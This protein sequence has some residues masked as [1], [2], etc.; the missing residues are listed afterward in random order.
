[1][2]SASC[3]FPYDQVENGFPCAWIGA[4][5]EQGSC[6]RFLSTH[7]S[8]VWAKLV[9]LLSMFGN[10]CVPCQLPGVMARTFAG[11]AEA[12]RWSARTARGHR[13]PRDWIQPGQL[14]ATL[15]ARGLGAQLSGRI[16]V[17]RLSQASGETPWETGGARRPPPIV[18]IMAAFGHAVPLVQS[19]ISPLEI[20]PGLTPSHQ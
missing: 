2:I 5:W 15:A 1:M 11:P 18:E 3:P 10:C 4:K 7:P 8:T 6:L 20:T 19:R 9:H 14:V 17:R 16:C 13:F 12:R